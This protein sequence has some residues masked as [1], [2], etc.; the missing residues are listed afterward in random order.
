MS[1]YDKVEYFFNTNT[2]RV[3]SA[4]PSL[5]DYAKT[6]AHL[7]PCD[8]EGR[9][10]KVD[11]D[12]EETDLQAL[13]LE[14]ET[15]IEIL[16][17]E[18]RELKG[19]TPVETQPDAPKEEP[20]DGDGPTKIDLLVGAISELEDGNPSHFTEAGVPRVEIL[21]VLSGFDEVSAAERDEAWSRYSS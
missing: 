4:N 8:A 14:R 6:K 13:L 16:K 20:K 12:N 15:E 2:H 19:E 11:G 9:M 3:V 21:E 18:L 7:V 5:R 17:A 10:L 1:S